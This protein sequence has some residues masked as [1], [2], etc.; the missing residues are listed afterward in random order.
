MIE[1]LGV[2]LKERVSVFEKFSNNYTEK[3]VV[4]LQEY[5]RELEAEIASCEKY[6]SSSHITNIVENRETMLKSIQKNKSTSYSDK[7]S[8]DRLEGELTVYGLS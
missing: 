8:I 3:E 4:R 5:R 2:G 6:L 7:P 1:L